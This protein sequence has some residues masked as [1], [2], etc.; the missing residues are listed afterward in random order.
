VLFP[1]A[2]PPTLHHSTH[3]VHVIQCCTCTPTRISAAC[4][5]LHLRTFLP[6]SPP[7]L[8]H[9]FAALLS[10]VFPTSCSGSHLPF[11]TYSISRPAFSCTPGRCHYSP[12][13][14]SAPA[15]TVPLPPS[16]LSLRSLF[17]FPASCPHS[18]P[19]TL[20][21]LPSRVVYDTTST[22]SEHIESESPKYTS[23]ELGV[24]ASVLRWGL[25]H[26]SPAIEESLVG[27]RRLFS[28]NTRDGL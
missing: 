27:R 16:S 3:L 8:P 10:L 18:A 20:P 6:L 24:K 19:F 15:P 14:L 1:H 17:H 12:F 22:I 2:T 9:R 21:L 28:S 5:Q 7:S 11:L 26:G 23:P 25:P 13:N 4:M